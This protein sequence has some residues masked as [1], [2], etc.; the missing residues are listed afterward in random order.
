MPAERVPLQA[1]M[2][3]AERRQSRSSEPAPLVLRV[4]VWLFYPAQAAPAA[5]LVIHGE[6]LMPA[7]VCGALAPP[8]PLCRYGVLPRRT[9]D[10]HDRPAVPAAKPS[11]RQPLH[12]CPDRLP[13]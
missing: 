10:D 9:Q 2:L 7:E 1:G 13:A 8:G 3:G 6:H 5:D 4:G 12:R 11:S